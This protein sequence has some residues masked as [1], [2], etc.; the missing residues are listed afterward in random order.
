MNGKVY[1]TRDSNLAAFLLASQGLL[2]A[3]EVKDGV[4]W[5]KYPETVSTYKNRYF[6]GATVEAVAYAR[7][8]KQVRLMVREALDRSGVHL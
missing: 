5:W 7:A 1:R 8:I 6:A 2:G 3:P 4:V